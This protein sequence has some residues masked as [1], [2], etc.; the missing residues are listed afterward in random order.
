MIIDL[1]RWKK[2]VRSIDQVSCSKNRARINYFNLDKKKRFIVWKKKSLLSIRFFNSI[3]IDRIVK[4]SSKTCIKIIFSIHAL[5]SIFFLQI[6]LKRATSMFV[7][8]CLSVH[9]YLKTFQLIR[10]SS[11]MIETLRTI[12]IHCSFLFCIF[13]SW[14]GYIRNPKKLW[15]WKWNLVFDYRYVTVSIS[16]N[17]MH[18]SKHTFPWLFKIWRNYV[19]WKNVKIYT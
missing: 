1:L 9:I 16:E 2:N 14:S 7:K 3:S 5:R 19:K 17:E 4:R 13:I 6:D 18:F 11:Q 8:M 15:F 10:K 12:L